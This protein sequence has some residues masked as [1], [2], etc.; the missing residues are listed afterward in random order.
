MRKVLKLGLPFLA[1]TVLAACAH[2]TAMTASL[3]GDGT[4]QNPGAWQEIHIKKADVLTKP[5]ADKILGNNV[6]REAVCK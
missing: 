6:A 3:C 1:A 4:P 2:D 5:T